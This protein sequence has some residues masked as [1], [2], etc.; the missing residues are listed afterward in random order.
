[1]IRATPQLH[2]YC[3]KRHYDMISRLGVEMLKRREFIVS[4][5]LLGLSTTMK[6]EEI[7]KLEKSFKPVKDVIAAVQAHMFP[8]GNILPSAEEVRAIDFLYGTM[9]HPSYDKDIRAFVIEG[10][11]E[12]IEREK[13]SFLRYNVEE[14]EKALRNY[15]ETNYGSAWLSRIMTLTM[16]G[17][18]SDPIYGANKKEIGWKSL[19]AYGGYPRAKGRYLENV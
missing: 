19:Q 6:A 4:S 12:L 1:M 15:E 16:E 13:K 14:K 2:L 3:T 7:N 9:M 8:K 10:A 18:F 5:V 11:Q 17:M